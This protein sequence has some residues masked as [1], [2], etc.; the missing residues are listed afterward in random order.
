ME[1]SV[2]ELKTILNRVV[3]RREFPC[4]LIASDFVGIYFKGTVSDECFSLFR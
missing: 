3:T 2:H 4:L 1:I